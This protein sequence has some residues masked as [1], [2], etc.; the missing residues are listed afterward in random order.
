MKS[1]LDINNESWPWKAS[2][3]TSEKAADFKNVIKSY[4]AYKIWNFIFSA[5]QLKI[6]ILY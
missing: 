1:S 4:F 3:R 5:V 6:Y 2:E